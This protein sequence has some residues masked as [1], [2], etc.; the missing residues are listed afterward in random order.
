MTHS[1]AVLKQALTHVLAQRD[2]WWSTLEYD[3]E[4]R[5]FRTWPCPIEAAEI[6]LMT[7]LPEQGTGLHDHGGSSGAFHVVSGV[8]REQVA[9][10]TVRGTYEIREK[11]HQTGDTRVFGTTYIHDMTNVEITPAVSIH[12]YAPSLTTLTR[13]HWNSLGPAAYMTDDV[14]AARA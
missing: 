3:P 14:S 1:P 12:I 8:V 2:Q 4:N 13:Y 5:W 10:R 9:T 11:T 6:R 7:W